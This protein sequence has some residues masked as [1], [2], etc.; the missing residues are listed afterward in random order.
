ML[1]SI[2][3]KKQSNELLISFGVSTL[4]I[5]LGILIAKIGVNFAATLI[6][7]P[8]IIG[9]L[10]YVFN[11]PRIGLLS[12]FHYSFVVNGL[13]RFLPPAIPFGLIVDGLLVITI[14]A[15]FF[16]IKKQQAS[17]INNT[18]FWLA[19]IWMGY[20]VFELFNPEA[21]SKEAWFYAMRGIG[22]YMVLQIPLTLILF[23]NREDLTLFIKMI[24]YWSLFAS[25]YAF[26]QHYIGITD[27]ERQWLD[28]GAYIT[29]CIHG[30]IRK[31][32]FYSDAGQFGAGMAHVA[33]FC[34]I[35][36]LSPTNTKKQKIFYWISFAILFWAYALSG[37]RGPL[38]VIITGMFLYLVI[39]GNL[40]ILIIG[41]IIGGL[42]F[43]VL[44]FTSIG[45]SNYQIQRM[46]TGLDPNDASLLVRLENQK[47]LK[48]YMASRPIGA[49]IGTGGSWGDRF[50]KG[51]WL[52]AVQ[53]DSWY[54]KIWVEMGVIGLTLHLI[55]LFICLGVGIYNTLRIKDPLLKTEMMA[56]CAGYFGIMFASY[57][58]Q[59]LGQNPTGYVMYMSMA[60]FFICI[61][62]VNKDGNILPVNQV[63]K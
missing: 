12:V 18:V 31:W 50:Y 10:I 25:L 4:A 34:I 47:Q 46:R 29:H 33:V 39:V 9:Y 8:F 17:Q 14:I 51:R 44:K 41:G 23:P 27:G 60:Y 43:G 53:L 15:C 58:N 32:S 40:R 26:K 3:K 21:T 57:G 19:L 30:R 13:T 37:S 42:F 48:G 20:I 52:S 56:L 61:K 35:L 63:D 45:S 55:H 24:I 6:C 16:S 49:G 38:F 22:L 36:A 11:N 28:D 7:A 62:W 59:I 5:F 1:T 2:R 54:V